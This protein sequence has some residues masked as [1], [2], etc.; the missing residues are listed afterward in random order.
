MS[1]T[2]PDILAC[3][4]S[5]QEG[6]KD[7]FGRVY[8][9]FFDPIYRYV[10]FRVSAQDVDDI[11]EN[12]FMKTWLNLPR[13][14]NQDGHFSSWVFKIAHNAVIDH[15]RTHRSLVTLDPSLKDESEEAAPAEK[16]ERRLMAEAVRKE[17]A[18]LKD[19]YRQVLSLKFLSGLSNA[20]IAEVLSER[21]ANVRL[22]QFRGLKELK[23]RF[24]EA[25]LHYETLF[26]Q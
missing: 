3:I 24:E 20:E 2:P 8:D 5:A 14:Q 16:T 13:Y 9:H 15:H 1:S 6:D 23:R 26:Q 7:A 4:A 19:P 22:I 17:L 25:G 21:E 18:G 10:F 12:V 11:V